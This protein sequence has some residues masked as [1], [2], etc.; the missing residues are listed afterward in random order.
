MKKHAF[1]L[2]MFVVSLLNGAIFYG[3]SADAMNRGI[4]GVDNQASLL[5]I[6]ILW[7]EAALVLVALYAVTLAQGL[8]IPRGQR[9]GLLDLFRL[10]ALSAKEKAHRVIF[11]AA[12]GLLMSFG[13]VLFCDKP[14][15]AVSYA[16]SG[17]VLLLFLYA[18]KKASDAYC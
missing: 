9:I 7:V 17:G 15:W 16:L 1:W 6:P 3:Y 13:Y 11:L 10:S 8:K 12:T 4:E 5:F 14:V 18:W 2:S